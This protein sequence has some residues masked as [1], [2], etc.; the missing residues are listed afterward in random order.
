VAEQLA[1]H[2]EALTGSDGCRG[3]GVTKIVDASVLEPGAG[4]DALPEGLQ[5]DEV[6][7]K[8]CQ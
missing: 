1:D 8:A 6:G 2:R 5:V 7:T 3:E 4:A